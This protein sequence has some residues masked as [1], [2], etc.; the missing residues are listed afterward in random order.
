M[1]VGKSAVTELTVVADTSQFSIQ[2]L[3]FMY[4]QRYLSSL[5]VFTIGIKMRTGTNMSD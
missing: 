5:H 2:Y 1:L 3:S 4:H